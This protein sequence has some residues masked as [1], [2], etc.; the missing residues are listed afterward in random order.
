[1]LADGRSDLQ[2]SPS[3]SPSRRKTTEQM[4]SLGAHPNRVPSVETETTAIDGSQASHG[5]WTGKV[6]W[7]EKQAAYILAVANIGRLVLILLSLAYGVPLLP[8]RSFPLPSALSPI[9]FGTILL[10]MFQNIHKFLDQFRIRLLW[11]GQSSTVPR[12]ALSCSRD[13]AFFVLT[14]FILIRVQ[15]SRS[16]SSRKNVPSPAVVDSYVFQLLRFGAC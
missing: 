16:L 1:M 9:R 12:F 13:C 8:Y 5:K 6:E 7:I 15:K 2:H 4:S 14:W 3:S 10:V 11:W